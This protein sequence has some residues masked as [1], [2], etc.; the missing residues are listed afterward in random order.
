MTRA[1]LRV[2]YG[3]WVM[4]AIGFIILAVGTTLFSKRKWRQRYETFLLRLL[5]ALIWP[6]ALCSAKGRKA[7]LSD[8]MEGQ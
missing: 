8:L 6:I 4:G 1:L 3:L 5:H 2:L 7:L